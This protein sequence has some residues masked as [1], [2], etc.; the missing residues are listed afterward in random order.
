MLSPRGRADWGH[1]LRPGT[2]E[3]LCVPRVGSQPGIGLALLAR[4]LAGSHTPAGSARQREHLGQEVA[5]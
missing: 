5:D 1:V 4:G 2:G 3:C